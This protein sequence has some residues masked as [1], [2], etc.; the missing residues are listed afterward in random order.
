M[1]DLGPKCI[2]FRYIDPQGQALLEGL[3][4]RDWFSEWLRSS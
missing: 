1:V 3:G 2:P 4:L